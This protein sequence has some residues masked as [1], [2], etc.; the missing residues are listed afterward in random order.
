MNSNSRKCDIC[1]RKFRWFI[2]NFDILV[3]NYN[4]VHSSSFCV[5]INLAFATS[6]IL[7]STQIINE[8]SFFLKPVEVW[9]KV[10]AF[11]LLKTLKSPWHTIFK[12]PFALLF[13][14]EELIQMSYWVGKWYDFFYNPNFIKKLS[15]RNILNSSPQFSGNN[16]F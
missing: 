4:F 13:Q 8:V 2:I 14:S 12:L 16:F 5:P 1:V 11:Y 6:L 7:N 15:F 10:M 9:S 3:D